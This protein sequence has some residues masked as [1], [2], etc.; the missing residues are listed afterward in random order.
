[1]SRPPRAARFRTR[2]CRR[3]GAGFLLLAAVTVACPAWSDAPTASPDPASKTFSDRLGYAFAMG[4][5]R[6]FQMRK[7]TEGDDVTEVRMLLF[8]PHVRWEIFDSSPRSRWYDGALHLVIEPELT[9]NF[10]PESTGVGGGVTGGLRYAL[11]PDRSWS[12]YAIGL[13]GVGAIDYDLLAQDDG[14]AFWLQFGLG[15]RR[16]L[17]PVALTGDVRLYHISNAGSHPPNEGI[18]MIA[19]TLGLETP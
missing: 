5:G 1:L 9:V 16:R 14:F 10:A 7:R 15:V 13:L 17:G 18:D 11:R 4:Y 3:L 6:G 2:R 8:M 19:F 12:P